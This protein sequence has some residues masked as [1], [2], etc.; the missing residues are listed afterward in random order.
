MICQIKVVRDVATRAR[1]SAIVILKTMVVNAPPALRKQLDSLGDEALID[2]CASLRPGWVTEAISSTKHTLG[3]LAKRWQFLDSEVKVH[4]SILAELKR[5]A[6][7]PLREGFGIGPDTSA[8]LLI[9]LGDNPDRVRCE[10]CFAKLCGVAPIPAS[11]GMTNRHR[12]AWN[13]HR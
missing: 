7:P 5:R 1:T 13:G 4:D 9:V 10:A 6:S 3:S 8:E 2:K 11:S 12:L